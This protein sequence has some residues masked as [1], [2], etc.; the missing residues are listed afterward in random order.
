MTLNLPKLHSYRCLGTFNFLFSN[1]QI[2]LFWNDIP[3]LRVC[4]DPMYI[5]L[6]LLHSIM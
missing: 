5:S 4:F 2:L 6:H 3:V 1:I